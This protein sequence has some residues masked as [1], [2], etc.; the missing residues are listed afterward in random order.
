MMRAPL[1]AL[2]L[3]IVFPLSVSARGVS[4]YLPLNLD[5]TI[6]H[7][8]E[9]VLILADKPALTRPFAAA[10]VLDALPAA[11][12][13]D[14]ELCQDVQRYLS[15]YMRGWGLTEA[16]IEVAATSGADTAVPNRYGM[17]SGSAWSAVL[18]G[19]WQPS[20][21]ALIS[22]GAVAYENE[23]VPEGSLVSLGWDRAQLDIGYRPHWL[24]PLTDSSM[25]SSTQAA[26]MPSVTISNY[27]PLTRWG[28]TYEVFVASMSESNTISFDNGL[29][30]GRPRL[31]GVHLAM[32]PASGWALGVNRLL[33]YGGGGR[34]GSFSDL[35]HAFFSP[36]RYDNTN[37]NLT[38]DQ[39]FGNQLASVTSSFLFPGKVPF[40]VYFEYAGEDTSAGR[41]YL[42]G[43]AALSAG[44]HF[45]RLWRRFDLTYEVSEWQNGWY[46]NSVYGDGLTNKGHVIG[47][48]GGD[49][50]RF[51]NDIGAQSHMLRVGWEPAFGGLLDVRFRT[52]ENQVS[53]GGGGYQRA[54]DGTV[55]YS[56]PLKQFTVGAEAFAGRDVFGE[57]FSR[58]AAFFRY[59]PSGENSFRGSFDGDDGAAIDPTAALFVEAGPSFNQVRI[60]LDAT[61]TPKVSNTAAHLAIGARRAVSDRSDLGARLE[62]DDV[63]G[64]S[65]LSVRAIDYRYR[66]ANPLA[67]SVFV[68]ASRYDLATPAFGL[69]Y[70][71]GV[72]W[73]DVVPGWDVGVDARTAKKVARDHLLPDDPSSALRP[74]S[75]YTVNSVSLAI[76]KRF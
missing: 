63:D 19:Y 66:F 34:P 36:S 53:Y 31:A 71:V 30:S 61:T 43:N 15:R 75:F 54:Y 4:P 60:D 20:D 32:E 9:R 45:P 68:G 59:D 13:V 76:T 57:S 24:S 18:R 37:P 5:P 41:N 16:S 1:A 40:A 73:R 69:Y 6:E 33:Q 39:Q 50:R 44:I 70:G 21:Y 74:D 55:S 10:T 7:Q 52:L 46:T 38:S 22:L 23:V 47:H 11:C 29:Q 42:L 64:H 8:I 51:G 14:P 65:L 27:T 28:L 56:R 12:K 26:T 35:L 17:T 72:Q 3:L 49:D 2:A 25:L 58:V 67:L 48:W 62:I